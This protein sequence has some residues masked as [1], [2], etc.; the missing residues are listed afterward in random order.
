VVGIAGWVSAVGVAVWIYVKLR[1]GEDQ[2][3][4]DLRL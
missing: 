4:Q 1:T 2:N 3:R